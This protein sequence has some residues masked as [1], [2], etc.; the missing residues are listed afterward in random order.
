MKKRCRSCRKFLKSDWHHNECRACRKKNKGVLI[1]KELMPGGKIELKIGPAK[2]SKVCDTCCK[3]GKLAIV[4]R[5][6]HVTGKPFAESVACEKCRSG[7]LKRLG[8][9]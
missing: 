4:K 1:A 9:V 8:Y 6:H 3:P 7:F 2:I 5:Y